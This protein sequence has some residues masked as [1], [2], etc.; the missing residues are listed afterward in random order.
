LFFIVIEQWEKL[1]G[2]V[3]LIKLTL[4]NINEKL[5]NLTNEAA[6]PKEPP[7]IKKPFESL[8]DFEK[9]DESITGDEE[10][11]NKLV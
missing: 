5:D 6:T 2:D 3:S 4:N 1:L 10:K 7:I 11:E 9:F 8:Q